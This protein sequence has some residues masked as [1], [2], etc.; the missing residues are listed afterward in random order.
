[1]HILVHIWKALVKNVCFSNEEK[2]KNVLKRKDRFVLILILTFWT[3][4][5][6]LICISKNN[7]KRKKNLSM[8]T[9]N[10]FMLYRGGGRG[11]VRTLQ[12]LVVGPIYCLTCQ[13]YR[14]S[15]LG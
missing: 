3:I 7:C 5:N 2:M 15:V 8:S 13:C 12:N 14:A 1:M 6:Q 9:K 4:L 11:G 10:C